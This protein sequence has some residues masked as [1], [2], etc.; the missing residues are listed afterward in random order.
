MA[1]QAISP[2]RSQ[3]RAGFIAALQQP[4]FLVLWLSEALSLIGDRLIIVALVTLVYERT[5][6][7]TAIGVLMMFKA[8]PSLALGS[9]AG[10][11]VDRWNRKWV[12]VASNLLQGL[13]VMLIPFSDALL[14]VFA[15]YL[16]MSV[17]NQFFV[18]ARAATIPN[19]VPPAALMAANSL[20][21]AAFVGAIA[22][23]PAI[24]GWIVEHFG[25]NAAFYVD[26]GTF[27]VPALA[28]SLLAIP[29]AHRLPGNSKLGADLSQGLAYVR[30][31]TDL[32]TALALIA[33]AFLTMGTT[34]VLGVM[35][36]QDTLHVGAGGFG[37]MMSAMGGGMLF[38]AVII[39]WLG[40]K[41]SR[42]WLG[43]A[44]ILLMGLATLALSWIAQFNLA[45]VLLAL[46]GLGL[47]TV[48]VCSQT[49]L[50]STP[51]NLH[52]RV[53]G[54]AQAI[55]GGAQFLASALAGLLAEHLGGTM[56]LMG[57]GFMAIVVGIV[58]IFQKRQIS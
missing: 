47:V 41:L 24:G 3:S 42:R 25:S 44:G 4:A 46:T 13:L 37:L 17:V 28:V 55:N 2:V 18:P 12:M 31:R 7:P 26:A 22:I 27:L 51:E 35:I 1:E 50:Q 52:G 23:G 43:V 39:G 40:R 48:Q 5:H 6:S 36:A 9:L 8:V 32:L 33:A 29:P 56:V 45:I 19:L 16:A 11:F 49:T 30:S 58:I 10:V 54:L 53:M 14:M 57:V 15:I 34:S 21:A 38:G 20:F